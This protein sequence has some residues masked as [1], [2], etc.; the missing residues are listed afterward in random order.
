LLYTGLGGSPSVW[1][2]GYRVRLLIGRLRVRP[3]SRTYPLFHEVMKSGAKLNG[4]V[5]D[6]ELAT[7]V[8]TGVAQLVERATFNR[9]VRGSI[10]LISISTFSKVEQNL[11]SIG[12]GFLNNFSQKL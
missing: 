8:K 5:S 10:P 2:N 4:W 6:E 7:F 11:L 9:V 1:R 3:P 12:E